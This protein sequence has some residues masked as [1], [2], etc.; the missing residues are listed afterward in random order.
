MKAVQ[1][2]HVSYANRRRDQLEFEVGDRVFLRVSPFKSVMRF[3]T[4]G[5]LAP[6]F[7]GP[8]DIIEM[9]GSL[10]Y[11]LRLPDELAAMHDVFHVSMLRTDEVGLDSTLSYVEYPV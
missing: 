5:K 11:R 9:I 4:K 10:A 8:F 7:V 6:K 2:R 1:D 3:R